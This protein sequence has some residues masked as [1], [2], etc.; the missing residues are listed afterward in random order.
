MNIGLETAA[1]LVSVI[2]NVDIN[3]GIGIELC[4]SSKLNKSAKIW[5]VYGIGDICK[6]RWSEEERMHFMNT[7]S[8]IMP[9]DKYL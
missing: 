4:D 8:P 5:H 2:W 3:N 6:V 9:V 7:V 1:D